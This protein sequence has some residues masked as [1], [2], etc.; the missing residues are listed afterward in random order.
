MQFNNHFGFRLSIPKPIGATNFALRKSLAIDGLMN[1]K[2]RIS[3]WLG[4]QRIFL[5]LTLLVLYFLFVSSVNAQLPAI[6]ISDPS[7]KTPKTALDALNWLE[8]TW[9]IQTG[10]TEIRTHVVRSSGGNYLFCFDQIRLEESKEWFSVFRIIAWNP[11]SELFNESIFFRDGSIGNATWERYDASWVVATKVILADGRNVT[12]INVLTP[13]QPHG[14]NWRS[15]SRTVDG[16][17]LPDL[18]PVVA[19]PIINPDLKLWITDVPIPPTVAAD[20]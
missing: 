6:V 9:S 13:I 19:K 10:T 16:F 7:K 8:G 3:N 2:T 1:T 4:S 20:E 17:P 18:G 11:I 12:A 5:F 15:E 14:F